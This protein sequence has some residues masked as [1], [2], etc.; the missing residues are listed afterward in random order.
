MFQVG[1]LRTEGFGGVFWF[2]C[3]WCLFWLGCL[4][5]L[6]HGLL[7]FV[8]LD[9]GF[10]LGCACF[11]VWVVRLFCV[12]FTVWLGVFHRLALVGVLA[13]CFGFVYGLW[14]EW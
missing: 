14:C 11:G 4:W 7:W 3:G 9:L 12:W 5:E 2:G 1:L 10:E 13:G 8:A 6:F